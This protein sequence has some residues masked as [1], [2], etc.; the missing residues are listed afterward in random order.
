MKL[1]KIKWF[2]ILIIASI[3][4]ALMIVGLI[5]GK[6]KLLWVGAGQLALIVMLICWLVVCWV[7]KFLIHNSGA[8]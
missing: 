1:R 4:L 3:L 6:E 5:T 2:G 8:K 7:L